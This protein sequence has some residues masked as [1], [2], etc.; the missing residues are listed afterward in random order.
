[1]RL[2]LI[3]DAGGQ[4]HRHPVRSAMTLGARNCDITVGGPN[5]ARRHAVIE[6]FGSG[7]AVRDLDSRTGTFVND[8]Q[9]AAVHPLAVGDII[10]VGSETFLVERVEDRPPRPVLELDRSRGDVPAPDPIPRA[11]EA[12]L[13]PHPGPAQFAPAPSRR[14]RRRSAATSSVATVVALSIVAGDCVAL[15]LYFGLK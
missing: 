5:V 9:L 7:F 1:M 15:I 2:V 4:R 12:K 6:H 13:R 3:Q 11:L 10:R 14:R 8:R